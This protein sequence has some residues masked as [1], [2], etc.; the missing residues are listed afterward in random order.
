MNIEL[1][2]LPADAA[3]AWETI[4]Y[5]T[6]DFARR[7]G[8]APSQ[9][10]SYPIAPQGLG[11]IMIDPQHAEGMPVNA[12]ARLLS[13]MGIEFRGDVLL[14]GR[15]HHG[16]IYDAPRCLVARLIMARPELAGAQAWR[17][18]I[19]T[20]EAADAQA[21]LGILEARG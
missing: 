20:E 8:V 16:E 3:P 19:T 9:L 10:A 7:L 11:L 21:W 6:P 13:G 4:E 17:S 1:I 12:A 5:G 18:L 14:A 2:Q 15:R